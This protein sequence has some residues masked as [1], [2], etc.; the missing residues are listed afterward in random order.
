MPRQEITGKTNKKILCT[1]L[2]PVYNEQYNIEPLI[3]RVNEVF[4]KLADVAVEIFFVDDGSTD[5]SLAVIKKFAVNYESIKYISFSRNFG[6]EFAT[7]AGLDFA[8]G[9]IVILIDADLQDPPEIIPAM[10]EK[11]REGFNVVYARRSVRHGESL[12]KKLTSWIFYRLL[13]K[14][15]EIKIPLDTGDFRLMDRNVV[16]SLKHCR[17]RN[18]F[19]RGMVAW[20]G[21][22]Q[23]DITYD[24]AARLSGETK[25][26][27]WKLLVLSIDAILGFSHLPLHLVSIF[28]IITT[29]FSLFIALLV[30]MHKLFFGL[31]IQ[32][33]ALVATGLF[34]FFGFI[35]FLLGIIGMY[36]GRMY[37]QLQMRP[38]YIVKESHGIDQL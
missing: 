20:V 6:H 5:A 34:S 24:R 35:T 13:N 9:D 18:R 3:T 37:T 23:T 27:F 26:S 2:I 21:F 29:V 17:E 16:D 36:I 38:L 14:L 7:T 12:Y 30:V 32:G 19:V 33:Y 11:W 31:Q 8:R 28:G 10:I 25:Y 4:D 1:V 15:A 22:N